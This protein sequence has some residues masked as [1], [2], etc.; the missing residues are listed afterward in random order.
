MGLLLKRIVITVLIMAGFMVAFVVGG[1]VLSFVID[2]L[3]IRG[4]SAGV[5]Y[6]I[7]FVAGVF[8]GMLGYNA[9]G[10]V[11][12]GKGE[13]DWSQRPGA[14]TVGWFIIGVT[15]IVAVGVFL[16]CRTLIW[17]GPPSDSF[18]VPESQLHTITYLATIFLATLVAQRLLGPDAKRSP[19]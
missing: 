19:A 13:L 17:T 7:W 2:I 8:C 5:F 6:A 3:P 18:F 4:H 9:A 15:L 10:L 14:A 16:V 1:V 12:S 11:L